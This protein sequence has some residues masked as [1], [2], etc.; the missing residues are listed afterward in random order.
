M[1]IYVIAS[2]RVGS[3]G[4]LATFISSDEA[5]SWF[6]SSSHYA[7]SIYI[8]SGM[9]KLYVTILTCSVL[10]VIYN[11]ANRIYM[12]GSVG[13]ADSSLVL[14]FGLLKW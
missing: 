8:S 12:Y 3:G 4:R 1:R 7:R 11:I 9:S 13:L 2:Y 10:S 6:G 5:T 14:Q